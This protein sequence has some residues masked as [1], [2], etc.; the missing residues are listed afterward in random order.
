MVAEEA[1]E[2]VQKQFR[3]TLFPSQA[4]T[5]PQLEEAVP[6]NA[7]AQTRCHATLPLSQVAERPLQAAVAWALG[8]VLAQEPEPVVVREAETVAA[9]EVVQAVE[10]A[11]ETEEA[12][13]WELELLARAL[14]P[15]LR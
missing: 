11:A 8:S 14:V 13:V 10:T 7:A 5:P 9:L 3:A 12:Q 4:A 15:A 1:E 6:V 2:G